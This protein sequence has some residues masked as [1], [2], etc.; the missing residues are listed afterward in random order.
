MIPPPNLIYLIPLVVNISRIIFKRND[1]TSDLCTI[2]CV[3]SHLSPEM[4]F[5]CGSGRRFVLRNT[6][7]D[8]WDDSNNDCRSHKSLRDGDNLVAAV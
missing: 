8:T 4:M 3:D 7:N 6:V 2:A 5:N 1:Q